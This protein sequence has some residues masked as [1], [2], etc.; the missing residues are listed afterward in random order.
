MGVPIP[1]DYVP[2]PRID[3]QPF[4]ELKLLDPT[5]VVALI[6]MYINVIW[7]CRDDDTWHGTRYLCYGR[8]YCLSVYLNTPFYASMV[9]WM[10][11]QHL[12]AILAINPNDG[13]PQWRVG[14][15]EFKNT[16]TGELLAQ[17]STTQFQAGPSRMGGKI[18]EVTTDLSKPPFDVG[19]PSPDVTTTIKRFTQRVGIR[20]LLM[21]FLVALR[22]FIWPHRSDAP[23]ESVYPVDTT[24]RTPTMISAKGLATFMAIKFTRIRVV[25]PPYSFNDLGLGLRELMEQIHV[26]SQVAFRGFIKRKGYESFAIVEIK[27]DRA[28]IA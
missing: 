15:E 26:E 8:S 24:I 23:I 22:T 12:D 5:D 2:T 7:T 27:V 4:G 28:Q 1:P 9:A 3:I 21:H 11:L 10:V 19:L 20:S 17:V 13:A 14:E 6:A 16:E 18:D 25:Q